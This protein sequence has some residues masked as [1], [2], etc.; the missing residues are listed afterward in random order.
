[1]RVIPSRA[2]GEGAHDAICVTQ[3]RITPEPQNTPVV[4]RWRLSRCEVG[5]P[6]LVAIP[7]SA[8][9]GMTR[10]YCWC[11]GKEV[12]TI[13][14]FLSTPRFPS[15]ATQASAL[16]LRRVMRFFLRRASL[17]LATGLLIF[18]CSCERHRVGELP[19][20]HEKKSGEADASKPH[21]APPARATPA[22][23]F[24]DKPKP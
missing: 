7:A 17:A 16:T 11:G 20:E 24:P 10:C 13:G 14:R 12:T 22:N 21:T 3:R 6:P 4:S 19:A 8:S 5:A 23:F 18:C 15:C 2:D 1:M 9:L